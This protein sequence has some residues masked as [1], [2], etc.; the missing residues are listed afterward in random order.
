[1]YYFEKFLINLNKNP[2]MASYWLRYS[3]IKTHKMALK[4]LDPPSVSKAHHI[5]PLLSSSNH[6]KYPPAI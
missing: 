4:Y 1:M 3:P 5:S 6:T 2:S